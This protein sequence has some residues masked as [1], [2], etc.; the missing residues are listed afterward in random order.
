MLDALSKL[1]ITSGLGNEISFQVCKIVN[2]Q[3]QFHNLH[4]PKIKFQISET[5]NNLYAIEWEAMPIVTQK[6]LTMLLPLMQ[7]PRILTGYQILEC[8]FITFTKVF[9]N[10]CQISSF[11]HQFL[12]TFLLLGDEGD[13]IFYTITQAIFINDGGSSVLDFCTGQSKHLFVCRLN[14]FKLFH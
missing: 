12:T 10:S 13:C 11:M 2:F 9:H 7:K 4:C 3:N 5:A 14:N 1:F 8:T 6:Y